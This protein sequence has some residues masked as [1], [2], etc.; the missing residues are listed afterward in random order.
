MAAREGVQGKHGSQQAVLF[1]IIM[2]ASKIIMAASKIIM[3]ASKIIMA[4][5]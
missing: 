1:K 3:A 5:R 2:A 4:A